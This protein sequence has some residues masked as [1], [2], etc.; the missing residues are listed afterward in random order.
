[1]RGGTTEAIV[2]WPYDKNWWSE[3]HA[4]LLASKEVPDHT[5]GIHPFVPDYIPLELSDLPLYIGWP[6]VSTEMVKLLKGSV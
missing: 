2:F 5:G 1:L 6:Y 3:H 4:L